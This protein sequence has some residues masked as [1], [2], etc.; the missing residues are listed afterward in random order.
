MSIWFIFLISAASGALFATRAVTLSA[1]EAILYC[2]YKKV[3]NGSDVVA[4]TLY[5]RAPDFVRVT[6]HGIGSSRPLRLS[7]ATLNQDIRIAGL[8]GSDGPAPTG[9]WA[10]FAWS[11][12]LAASSSGSSLP[13]LLL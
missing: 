2:S 10:S 11:F 1:V 12:S 3:F 6:D 13:S 9:F 5:L 8:P 7:A 4:V